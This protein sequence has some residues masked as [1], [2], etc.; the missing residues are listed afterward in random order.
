[1]YGGGGCGSFQDGLEEFLEAE[2]QVESLIL[3]VLDGEEKDANELIFIKILMGVDVV[4]HCDDR[5]TVEV[6][7]VKIQAI[8]GQEISVLLRVAYYVVD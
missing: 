2:C 7:Q 4:A 5:A 8:L 6:V 1:M 3:C